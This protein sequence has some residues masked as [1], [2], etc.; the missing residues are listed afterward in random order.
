[1]DDFVEYTAVRR[2]GGASSLLYW[3]AWAGMA[4]FAV[5]ALISLSNFVGVDPEGGKL[6]FSFPALLLG[7]AAVGLDQ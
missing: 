2:G 4:V 7:L 1:M 5:L 3:L 6:A